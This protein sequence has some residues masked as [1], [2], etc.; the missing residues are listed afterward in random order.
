MPKMTDQTFALWIMPA[1]D[2][3]EVWSIADD[4]GGARESAADNLAAE[5]AEDDTPT[6]PG[7]WSPDAGW[8]VTVRITGR[9]PD[10]VAAALMA[11]AEDWAAVLE[12]AIVGEDDDDDDDGEVIDFAAAAGV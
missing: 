4:E 6:A 11:M 8:P 3:H 2:G 9:H 5:S 7:A 1:S 10:Q 12:S